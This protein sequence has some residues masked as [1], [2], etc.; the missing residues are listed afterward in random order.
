[1]KTLL[2]PTLIEF[3]YQFIQHYYIA[4]TIFDQQTYLMLTLIP[5]NIRNS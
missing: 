2:Q 4:K 5:D 1:M 3:T